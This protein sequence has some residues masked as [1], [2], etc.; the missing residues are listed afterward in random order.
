MEFWIL[1]FTRDDVGVSIH[2]E[3]NR[4]VLD[5]SGSVVVRVGHLSHELH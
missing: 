1:K 3:R 2:F 4:V 5:Q